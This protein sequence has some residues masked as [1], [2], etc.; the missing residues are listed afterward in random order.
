MF[1]LTDL[2]SVC[3]Q[4][5]FSKTTFPALCFQYVLRFVFFA[6]LARPGD[7]MSPGNLGAAEG[8]GSG[9]FNHFF[10]RLLRLAGRASRARLCGD[11]RGHVVLR[12]GRA[13]PGLLC[14]R[15]AAEPILAALNSSL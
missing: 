9:I 4:V 5:R 14:R 8:L 6:T 15:P 2:F 7:I 13:G 12:P 11:F 1:L 10:R 3:S